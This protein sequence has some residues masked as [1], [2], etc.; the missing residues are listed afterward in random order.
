MASPPEMLA[1]FSSDFAYCPCSVIDDGMIHIGH[2]H[3][4][5][6]PVGY[7]LETQALKCKDAE[8]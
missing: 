6:F 8:G 1:L 7:L 2:A 3:L 5:H 4:C